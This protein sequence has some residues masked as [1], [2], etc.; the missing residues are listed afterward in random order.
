MRGLH[1]VDNES[2]PASNKDFFN[3]LGILM[4]NIT[5]NYENS[6][7]PTRDRCIDESLLSF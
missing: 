5:I 6:V 7:Y 4:T 3:K 2:V 1:F